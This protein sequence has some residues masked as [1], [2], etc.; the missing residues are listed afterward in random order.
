[1]IKLKKF[2]FSFIVLGVYFATA[3]GIGSKGR[4]NIAVE[5]LRELLVRENFEEIYRHTSGITRSQVSQDEFVSR[6]RDATLQMKSIDPEI[7]WARN[8]SILYDRQVFHDDNFSSLDLEQDGR[9]MNITL[10]WATEYTLCGMSI[11]PDA[12]KTGDGKGVKVFRNCD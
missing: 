4:N 10:D 5:N 11:I 8:E 7:R 2:L 1:M 6:I 3:C 9:R 12:S